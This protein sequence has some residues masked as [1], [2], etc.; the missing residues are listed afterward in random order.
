MQ[1]TRII[2]LLEPNRECGGIRT[3]IT[4]VISPTNLDDTGFYENNLHCN[5][6]VVAGDDRTIDYE[7]EL[8][9]IEFD[10]KCRYDFLEVL[11]YNSLKTPFRLSRLMMNIQARL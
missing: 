6:T 7:F 4:G 11:Q 5:W 1:I 10:Y 9:D 8:L 3:H 2:Y